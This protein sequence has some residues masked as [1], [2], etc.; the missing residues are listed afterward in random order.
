MI[1][2]QRRSD[3]LNLIG[4]HRRA[5][6]AAADRHA[7]I[8]L[9][10]DQGPRERDHIVGIVI[11]L[12]QTM[13]AEIDDLMARCAKLCD[14]FLFQTK[15]TMISGNS[16]AHIFSLRLSSPSGLPRWL[17]RFQGDSITFATIED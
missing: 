2:D 15:S 11:A 4:T 17:K 13:S 6:A 12:T 9:P 7:T 5:D 10:R 1:M 8:H 16:H 3:T 14:Q